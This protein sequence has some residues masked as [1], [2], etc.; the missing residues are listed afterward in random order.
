[1][2]KQLGQGHTSA[3]LAAMLLSIQKAPAFPFRCSVL[4]GFWG[5]GFAKKKLKEKTV[6]FLSAL[7]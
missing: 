1:M 2:S 4:D 5:R 7:K 3:G 6:C